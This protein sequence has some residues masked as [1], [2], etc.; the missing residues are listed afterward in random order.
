[1]ETTKK[2]S[3]E[4]LLE[5]KSILGEG[6]VWDWKRQ[7]L[8]WVDIEGC[9]LHQYIP[10][11]K[12]HQKWSFEHTLGAVAPT[13]KGN[14][15]LALETALATFEPT[16]ETVTQLTVLQN[17]RPEMRYNDGKVGPNGN[18]WIGSMHKQLAPNSGTLYRVDNRLNATQEISGTTISNGMAWS[19][20]HKLFYY[21][22]TATQQVAQFSFD[23]STSSITNRK[24]AFTI[25]KNFGAPDGMTI[26]DEGMLWIA[27]WGGNAVR[28][29]N[30]KTGELLEK[31][32]LP[33]PNVTSCCF[34]GEGLNTLYI[35]TARSGLNESQLNLF[36]LSG[37]LFTF[38]TRVKGTPIHY[39]K[40]S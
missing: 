24:I 8:F 11:G 15:L 26:D 21:I 13:E 30:P 35:T 39:F 17:D 1:M 40:G 5:T 27:H 33:A 37:G 34:G 4:L 23:K 2:H 31:I 9:M 7:A 32:E 38:Q 12:K 22:D 3:A 18:F 36:P 28:R 20:N 25:P 6:P 14:L 29:W 16:S 10:I 19:A